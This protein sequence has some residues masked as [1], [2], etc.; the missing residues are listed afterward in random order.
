MSFVPLVDSFHKCSNFSPFTDEAGPDVVE[1]DVNMTAEELSELLKGKGV[2][3]DDCALFRSIRVIC[4]LVRG[5]HHSL[6]LFSSPG[7]KVNGR[8]FSKMKLAHIDQ[9]GVS[10]GSRILIE[11]L[12][13][14]IVSLCMSQ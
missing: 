4:I 6:H 10:F 14:D 3:E 9:M 1:F 5:R 7:L 11:K 12:L 8:A 2:D 13:E